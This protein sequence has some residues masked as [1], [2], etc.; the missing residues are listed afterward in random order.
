MT[1]GHHFSMAFAGPQRLPHILGNFQQN[2]VFSIRRNTAHFD[3]GADANGGQNL[4]IQTSALGGGAEKLPSHTVF[5]KLGDTS[6]KAE[7]YGF[8]E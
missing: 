6:L 4:H 7:I 1:R 8:K 3:K 2:W 5:F